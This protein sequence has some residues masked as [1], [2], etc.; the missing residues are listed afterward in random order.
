MS[1]L[2]SQF[3][4]SFSYPYIH[5][6]H[7]HLYSCP[8]T[9]FT[10]TIFL[11]STY[12]Q[13]YMI[14]VFLFLT[15]FTLY[16]RLLVYPHF[17]KWPNFIPFYGWVIFHC[18][19]VPHLLYL[20]IYLLLINIPSTLVDTGSRRTNSLSLGSRPSNL[21]LFSKLKISQSLSN[22]FKYV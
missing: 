17:Y 14:F 12:K 21:R 19:Y 7:L 15:Y 1:V 3:I 2:I 11:E 4:P 8:R 18:I 16:D 5:S 20:F 10:C 13:Y 22:K 6:L 9:R